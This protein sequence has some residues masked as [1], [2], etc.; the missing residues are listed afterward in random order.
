MEM[1]LNFSEV[2][3]RLV[4]ILFKI[5]DTPSPFFKI[6]LKNREQNKYVFKNPI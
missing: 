2:P 6:G 3:K 4:K 1:E 5:V